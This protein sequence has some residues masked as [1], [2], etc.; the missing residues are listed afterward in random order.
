ME[1]RTNRDVEEEGQEY[2]MERIGERE[3]QMSE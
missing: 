3:M 2:K 1:R